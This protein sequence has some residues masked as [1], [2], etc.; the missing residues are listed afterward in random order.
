MAGG[1]NLRVDVWRMTTGDD[2]TVGGASITGTVVYSGYP[3]RIQA[4]EEEQLFLEQGMETVRVFT[5]VAQMR[6]ADTVFYERDELEVVFPY[7]HP[8][9]DDRFRI[10][11]MRYSDLQPGDPRA[12]VI[13]K[14]S[15]SVRAHGSQ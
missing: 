14:L 3:M 6:G 10:I 4:A 8:Y 5:G 11:S 7:N 2:D 1:L 15:R 13:M 9:A 12:N